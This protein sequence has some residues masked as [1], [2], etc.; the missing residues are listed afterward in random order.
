MPWVELR[1]NLLGATI[2]LIAYV[3]MDLG[4]LWIF[5]AW[6][7]LSGP[8][9]EILARILPV[10][11]GVLI[12]CALAWREENAARVMADQNHAHHGRDA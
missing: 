12:V 4:L 9:P 3:T 11:F 1:N 6:L 10:I 2:L 5:N 8:W 7:I